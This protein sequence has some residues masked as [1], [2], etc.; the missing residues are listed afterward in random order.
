LKGLADVLGKLGP[1]LGAAGAVVGILTSML[2]GDPV[3][4]KLNEISD[5]IDGIE[6]SMNA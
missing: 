4:D 3:M 5:K 1:F 6:T 2:G